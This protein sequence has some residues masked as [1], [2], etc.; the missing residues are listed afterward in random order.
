MCKLLSTVAGRCQAVHILSPFTPFSTPGSN[1]N[2]DSR[3]AKSKYVPV[4]AL[5]H[6]PLDHLIFYFPPYPSQ[7]KL[8]QGTIAPF[9]YKK[10][11]GRLSHQKR[12]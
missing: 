4:L 8:M 5:S 12:K 11:L 10:I 7:Q 9:L 3:Q 6:D 2:C 1:T